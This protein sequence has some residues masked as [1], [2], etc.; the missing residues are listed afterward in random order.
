MQTALANVTVTEEQRRQLDR[1]GYFIT[2]VLFDD[3]TLEAVRQEF[4]RFWE[5][6]IAAAE[7]TDD[8][9]RKH[10]AKIR[11]HMAQLDHKS[12]T[13]HAFC[14]HPVFA[15]ICRQL[16]GPDAD[17][18]WNQAILKAPAGEQT[19]G[20]EHNA[21]GWHQ[22]MYYALNGDF[23]NDCNLDKLTDP[24]NGITCWIAITRTTVDNGTMWVLPGRH[25]EGL[26]PHVWSQERNEYQGQFDVSWRV[27]AVL[28]AGQM[29][30]FRKYLPHYSSP[31][32]SNEP[33]MAYQLGYSV[34]GINKKP[35]VNFTP[36][37][38][39]GKMV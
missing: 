16:I 24:V 4:K 32:V 38:R 17:M 11:P 6:E 3:A 8:A 18:T 13:C 15:E 37:L 5:A 19:A 12:P 26:L 29:L 20:T 27:P 2:D 9:H 34:P 10:W 23:K 28:R 31:N 21:L 14:H 25:M 33:R 1:D 39:D 35:S 22:D 36:V 30:I 7:K